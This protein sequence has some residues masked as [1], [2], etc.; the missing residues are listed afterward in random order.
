MEAIR[1]QPGGQRPREAPSVSFIP[2]TTLFGP[3]DQFDLR[4]K[5]QGKP[6]WSLAVARFRNKKCLTTVAQ[7]VY[8]LRV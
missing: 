3:I 4:K 5:I 2:E 8:K 1:D 6:W 7:A